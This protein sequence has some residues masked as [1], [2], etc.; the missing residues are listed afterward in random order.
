MKTKQNL[1][2]FGGVKGRLCN[3]LQVHYRIL[4][5]CIEHDFSLINL[6]LLKNDIQRGDFKESLAGTPNLKYSKFALFLLHLYHQVFLFFPV[7]YDLE[8]SRVAISKK[9]FRKFITKDIETQKRKR[10]ATEDVHQISQRRM[11]PMRGYLMNVNK[12][13]SYKSLRVGLHYLKWMNQIKEKLNT[14][15]VIFYICSDE[16][17]PDSVYFENNNVVLTNS[18][19]AAADLCLLSKMDYILGPPSTFSS[20]ASYSGNVPLCHMQSIND[21]VE[22]ERFKINI[23][24]W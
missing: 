5:F 23:P 12:N 3:R 17:P 2:I 1:I 11:T 7:K 10:L 20:W 16:T 14:D 13:L 19:S 8:P 21:L 22:L 4:D 24:S 9:N 15:K 18:S 6:D